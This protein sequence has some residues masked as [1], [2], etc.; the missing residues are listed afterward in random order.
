MR[1]SLP[2]HVPRPS[3]GTGLRHEPLRTR[4][5]RHPW[6]TLA[7]AALLLLIAAAYA[8]AFLV[9]EPIRREMER[10][11]NASLKGYTVTVGAADFHPFGFSLDLENLSVVQDAAPEPP[12]AKIAEIEAS[13]QWRALLSGAVVADMAIVR[14]VVHLLRTQAE[15]ETADKVPLDERGWQDAVQE[16]YPLEINEFRIV[17]GDVTYVDPKHKP[18][19][20]QNLDFTAENIRNVRSAEGTYPS[21]IDMRARMDKAQL[22]ARGA[23]DFLA[24]PH[25][26]M[27]IDH[28]SLEDLDIGRLKPLLLEVGV[29]AR[30]GTFDLEGRVE[31]AATR[32]VV[33]LKRIAL[34]QAAIDYRQSGP[35]KVDLIEEG[36]ELAT[37]PE[38]QPETLVKVDQIRISDSEIGLI[39]AGADPEYR[40][41]L[42]NVDLTIDDFTNAKDAK[43]G[44]AELRGRFMDSGPTHMVARFQPAAE[45]ADFDIDLKIQQTDV[46]KLNDLW[47]A[48]GNFDVAG[49]HF[50][51][52]SEIRVH[53]G[54]VDGYVKPL[55]VD[56]DIYDAQQEAGDNIFQKAYEG[57][58]GGVATLLQNRP[59]DQVATQTDL[60]GP[61]KD[62]R[63]S[64]LQI[65]LG[66]IRNAF[67]D[68]ILPGLEEG[69]GSS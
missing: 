63:T 58:V 25:P 48:Y 44:R 18:V 2:S 55:F 20:V 12:V 62:P 67:F 31:Y 4:V 59:R 53:E 21:P 5:R 57:V 42:S 33:D 35:Q 36:V 37:T 3:L 22:D 17:D 28:L 41:F 46:T 27:R 32:T 60:S 56:L 9:D 15:K 69:R 54:R 52:F 30:K 8:V 51:L 1:Q 43:H 19:R 64:T 23:A 10:R 49:G 16:I 13:V 7:G 66:L 38:K 50:S 34:R 68:A 24:A 6:L 61:V 40:L 47:R 29:E 65:I 26:T 11:L 14:P 45:Q 39:N